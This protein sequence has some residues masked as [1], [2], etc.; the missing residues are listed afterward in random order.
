[1]SGLFLAAVEKKEKLT[2]IYLATRKG[3]E[4]KEWTEGDRRGKG[5]ERRE[6][7]RRREKIFRLHNIFIRTL[8]IATNQ[9]PANRQNNKTI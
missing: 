7:K 3:N 6:E 1:M 2:Q 8:L 9:N 4:K 5:I